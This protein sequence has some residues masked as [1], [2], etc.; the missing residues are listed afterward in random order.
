MGHLGAVSL[1]YQ[2]F[3]ILSVIGS[4]QHKRRE[5]AYKDKRH[6]H[7]LVTIF[8]ARY[9]R[10]KTHPS[11]GGLNRPVER[12]KSPIERGVAALGEP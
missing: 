4:D 5:F 1:G 11:E 10:R 6:I 8:R 7:Q 3:S 2:V 9:P 12:A